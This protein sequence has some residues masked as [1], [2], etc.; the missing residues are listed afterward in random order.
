MPEKGIMLAASF[1]EPGTSVL[2]TN[3]MNDE[4][5]AP[6]PAAVEGVEAVGTFRST[7]SARPNPDAGGCRR[8]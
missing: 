8:H 3:Q 1:P 2:I 4:I 7:P 5:T 6:L